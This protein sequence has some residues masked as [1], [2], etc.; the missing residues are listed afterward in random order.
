MQMR[1]N[2]KNQGFF[3]SKKGI[4]LTMQLVVVIIILL[5]ILAFLLIFFI[6]RGQWLSETWDALVGGALNQSL[7]AT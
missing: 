4:E 1:L 3:K 5:V 2:T 7:A 6:G